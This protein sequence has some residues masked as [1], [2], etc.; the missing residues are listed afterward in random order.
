MY[1]P[2]ICISQSYFQLINI[3]NKIIRLFYPKTNRRF[4]FSNKIA[5]LILAPI[6][7]CLSIHLQVSKSILLSP[8]AQA[9]K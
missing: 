6:R 3:E 2:L 1:E 9:R 7:A 4:L 5:L 8:V